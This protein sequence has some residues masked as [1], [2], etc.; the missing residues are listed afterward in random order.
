[1]GKEAHGE[2]L[3]NAMAACLKILYNSYNMQP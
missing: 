2:F 3:I 1:M